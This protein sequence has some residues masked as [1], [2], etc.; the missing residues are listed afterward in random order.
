MTKFKE[1]FAPTVVL[2]L[3]CLIAA[4]LLG[5]TNQVTAPRIEQIQYDNEVAAR[6]VVFAAADSF[7][8]P[9]ES[10]AEGVKTVVPALDADGKVIGCVVTAVT[11]GYGG[12]I[13]VMTGVDADG[14]VTGV[15]IL[16]MSETAGLGANAKKQSFRDQFIGK[17][18]GVTVSKDQPGENAIDA[19]TGATITS[20]AVTR[21]VNASIEAAGGV[22]NG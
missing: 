18:A 8:D 20:R 7:G 14:A 12:D 6:K 3:V 4:F 16:D 17:I 15:S 13:T 19:L 21:A 1:Y 11:K 22:L 9:A 5:A 2:F 10:S